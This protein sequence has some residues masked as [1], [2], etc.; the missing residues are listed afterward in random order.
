LAAPLPVAAGV[1][2]AVD[3][4]ADVLPVAAGVADALAVVAGHTVITAL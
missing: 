2:V 4:G 1:G 3:A